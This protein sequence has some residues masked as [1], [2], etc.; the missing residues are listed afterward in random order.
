MKK[1]FSLLIALLLTSATFAQTQIIAHRGYHA[2]NSTDNS[3]SSLKNA[4]DIK[5]YGSEC[6]L[7]MTADGFIVVAHGPN[8]GTSHIQSSDFKTLRQQF[9][10]T[11]EVLPLLDE[12]LEVVKRRPETKLIIEIKEHETPAI[13]TEL[14]KKV[15][16]MVKKYK[17]EEHVEYISFR[18]HI[19]NQL[20]ALGSKDIKVA[21]LN[22]D[23]TPEYCKGLG[24]TGID[25]NINVM[26]KRPEW[27]RDAHR[28]DMTVNV[29]TVN[30]EENLKWCVDN[31]VDFIT[32]DKPEEAKKIAGSK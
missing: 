8:H 14:V 29:W 27:I 17:L 24:Y 10:K 18:Q 5:V 31:K 26:K 15:L 4:Q 32:T 11:G 2:K 30:D 16:K 1:T 13:E 23:L 28:F 7:N 3:L 6:D 9:L 22:G 20:V 21:Y 19:C 12:Y 25:Y